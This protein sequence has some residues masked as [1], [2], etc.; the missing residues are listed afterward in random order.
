MTAATVRAGTVAT[1]LLG[2]RTTTRR[3]QVQIWTTMAIAILAFMGNAHSVADV[4]PPSNLSICSGTS[5]PRERGSA[6][7]TPGRWWNPKRYGT[8]W[9]FHLSNAQTRL[10]AQWYT[11]DASRRPTWL[12]SLSNDV[13][14]VNNVWA[15]PL[16]QYT[17]DYVNNRRNPGVR[18]GSVALRFDPNN[19]ARVALRWQWVG[20]QWLLRR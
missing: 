18:V 16:Y 1:P 14:P 6:V 11:Y 8:G 9:D 17:W 5:L 10:L 20:L 4:Q 19:P 2:G 7:V 3:M 15:S 13:D 12:L